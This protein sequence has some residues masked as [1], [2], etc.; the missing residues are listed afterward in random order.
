MEMIHAENSKTSQHRALLPLLLWWLPQRGLI[1]TTP[2][3]LLLA[4]MTKALQP[5]LI[6]FVSAV[7][8]RSVLTALQGRDLIRN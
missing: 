7:E 2:Q 4:M 3:S 5:T 8:I 6:E 1:G